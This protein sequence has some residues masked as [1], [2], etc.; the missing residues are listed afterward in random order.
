MNRKETTKALTDGLIITV[1]EDE[2]PTNIYNSSPL[3]DDEAFTMAIK[4]LTAI[5]T[6][7][8]FNPGEIRAYGPIPTPK[9]PYISE[10]FM[11]SL[12]AKDSMDNR[13]AQFGRMIFFWIITTSN[14]ISKYTEFLK[15]MVKRT[16]RVYNIVNDKDLYNEEILKK[17]DE[18]IQIIDSGIDAYY[19][20]EAETIE[21]FGNISM[22]PE[23]STILLVTPEKSQIQVIFRDQP[24]PI[25]K[26]KVRS[27]VD[28]FKKKMP[29]GSLYRLE[30]VTDPI[31]GKQLL[32]KSGLESQT[33]MGLQ[34]RLRL[35]GKLDF[36]ELDQFLTLPVKK[37]RGVL[38]KR[39]LDAF[40][41]KSSLDLTLLA[42]EVGFSEKFIIEVLQLAIQTNVM[43]GCKVEGG[44]LK[45][46]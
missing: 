31:M 17:I 44:L 8:P 5:G 39:I 13:I 30:I 40:N 1:F 38:A 36:E 32:S 28:E 34:Y 37:I 10:A 33:D 14:S 27:I 25:V 6:S 11:F 15:L 16:L 9:D 12:A 43:S 35:S 41:N 7:Q 24:T 42:S 4:T 29:R 26:T 20:T 45:F 2:G 23:N 21:A 46:D 22:I 3:A 18:N 19:L